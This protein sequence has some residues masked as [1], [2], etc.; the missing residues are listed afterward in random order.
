LRIPCSRKPDEN[1]EPT[2]SPIDPH[3]ETLTPR[4]PYDYD[5]RPPCIQTLLSTSF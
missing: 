1:A 5:P 4:L 3:L 2:S